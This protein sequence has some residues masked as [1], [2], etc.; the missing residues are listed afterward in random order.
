MFGRESRLRGEKEAEKEAFLNETEI[1]KAR[2]ERL[3]RVVGNGSLSD[4]EYA[5]LL[6]R[7]A[8]RKN[9]PS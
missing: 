2:L 9:R 5:R 6:H 8:A 1:A 4:S 3:R 7:I